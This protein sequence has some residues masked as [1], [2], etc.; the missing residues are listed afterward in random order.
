MDT[1]II[2]HRISWACKIYGHVPVVLSQSSPGGAGVTTPKQG[3][4]VFQAQV[5]QSKLYFTAWYSD[6]IKA[7]V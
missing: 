3:S 4:T 5:D 7:S 2:E 6:E 1:K